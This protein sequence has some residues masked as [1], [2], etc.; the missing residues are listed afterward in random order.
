MEATTMVH[1]ATPSTTDNTCLAK[2]ILVKKCYYSINGNLPNLVQLSILHHSTATNQQSTQMIGMIEPRLD[3][4]SPNHWDPSSCSR[5]V[6]LQKTQWHH[7][8][9]VP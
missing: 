2:P 9:I 5:S 7:I 6:F 8:S 1:P 4:S 3:A